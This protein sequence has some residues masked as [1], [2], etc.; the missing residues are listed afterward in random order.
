MLL[1]AMEKKQCR[2]FAKKKLSIVSRVV[3]CF[4]LLAMWQKIFNVDKS[5]SLSTDKFAKWG[6]EVRE[7]RR[8]SVLLLE[9]AKDHGEK[10]RVGERK[11]DIGVWF[12]SFIFTLVFFFK[13]ILLQFQTKGAQF[14]LL[15]VSSRGGFL[16]FFCF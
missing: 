15:I 4:S 5:T 6:G 14:P 12:Y 9:S 11:S 13:V 2:T 7:L 1:S 16:L 8:L 3:T 10:K